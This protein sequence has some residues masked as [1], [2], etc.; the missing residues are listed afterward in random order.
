MEQERTGQ[1]VVDLIKKDPTNIAMQK[2]LAKLK[3]DY[4]EGEELDPN[5]EM[6]K[7]TLKTENTKMKSKLQELINQLVREEL[8]LMEKKKKKEEVDI[9][10][11]IEDPEADTETADDAVAADAEEMAAGADVAIDDTS[12]DLSAGGTGD[13]KEIGQHLQAALE[14]AKK[15]PASETKDKL[16]RQIGNTALFFLKTQIPASGDQI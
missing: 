15:L 6:P 3:A 4:D 13:A 14:A 2:L 9:D 7:N 5:R 8:S 12:M 16:I 1:K 10:L 11:D